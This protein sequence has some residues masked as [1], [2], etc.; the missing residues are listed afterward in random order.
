MVSK[1]CIICLAQNS[2]GD[3][4]RDSFD[5]KFIAGDSLIDISN[6]AKGES[7]FVSP[8]QIET[9]LKRHSSFIYQAKKE[10]SRKQKIIVKNIT[11]ERKDADEA[12]DR[13]INSGDK[14]VENW[15]KEQFEG[16]EVAGPKLPV[17][18]RLYIEALREQGRRGSMTKFDDMFDIMEKQAIRSG[19]VEGEVV[20]EP[21]KAGEK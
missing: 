9:H 7:V 18:E 20:Q 15:Q 19:A 2:K 3:P 1:K 12:L 11:L 14:M 5:A 4:L 10:T 6:W 8:R 13:I 21:K 16:E 17:T